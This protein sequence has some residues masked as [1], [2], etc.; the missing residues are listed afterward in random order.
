MKVWRDQ[1]FYG[2]ANNG[3]EGRSQ[4]GQLNLSLVDSLKITNQS[5]YTQYRN[6]FVL[7]ICK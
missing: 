4:G 1:R 7:K 6:D 5:S 3:K 2:K